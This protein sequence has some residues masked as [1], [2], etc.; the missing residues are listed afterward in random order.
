MS[1]S[2]GKNAQ[3]RVENLLTIYDA[4]Q[5]SDLAE[6][7]YS[8]EIS[9]LIHHLE[10][11]LSAHAGI[12][13]DAVKFGQQVEQAR[14]DLAY[15]KKGKASD[16]EVPLLEHV[17]FFHGGYMQTCHACHR[18]HIAGKRCSSCEDCAKKQLRTKY[19]D[20]DYTE[21]DLSYVDVSDEGEERWVLEDG[22][23]VPIPVGWSNEIPGF[24][25]FTAKPV[26]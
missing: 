15:F 24:P 5:P 2:L 17:G 9:P 14:N 7:I 19:P 20:A 8:S 23:I 18:Q 3:E 6:T 12:P 1:K 21:A 16:P 11:L 22:R 13:I 26:S 10:V 25:S 4:K